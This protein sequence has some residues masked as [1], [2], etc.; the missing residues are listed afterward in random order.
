MRRGSLGACVHYTFQCLDVHT[1]AQVHY[2]TCVPG[3][4]RKGDASHVSPIMSLLFALFSFF[5]FFSFFFSCFFRDGS[6]PLTNSQIITQ[7]FV[8]TINAWQVAQVYFWL[9]LTLK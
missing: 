6:L 7:S 4:I 2:T 8:I 3:G 9:V 1:C 5:L